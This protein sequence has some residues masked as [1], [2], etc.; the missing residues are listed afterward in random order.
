MAPYCCT[1]DVFAL[2]QRGCMCFVYYVL[3]P[4]LL[5]LTLSTSLSLSL[6]LCFYFSFSVP[7]QHRT[8]LLTA[9]THARSPLCH[10]SA[11]LWLQVSHQLH[12]CRSAYARSFADC[13]AEAKKHPCHHPH[14]A[15]QH[16]LSSV[17]WRLMTRAFFTAVGGVS[18][19]VWF[20]LFV[21]S[22]SHLVRI[23]SFLTFPSTVR[24]CAS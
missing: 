11:F 14:S 4:Y 21:S 22:T 16:R 8:S 19:S 2:T 3:L 6:S 1:Q 13:A 15:L 20:R 24:V 23:H 9:A 7:C 10:S 12:L 17:G 18:N 5:R